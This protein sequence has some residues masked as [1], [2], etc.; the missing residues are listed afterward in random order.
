MDHIVGCGLL[1]LSKFEGSLTIL[2]EAEEDAD[3]DNW[4]NSVETTAVVK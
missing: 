3:S 4:L 1:T 2:N